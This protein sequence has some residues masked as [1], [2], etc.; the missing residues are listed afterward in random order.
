VAFVPLYINKKL[1]LIFYPFF[2]R[3]YVYR[4]AVDKT[5]SRNACQ[6]PSAV[7]HN[8][9]LRFRILERIKS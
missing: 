5:A 4:R 7:H 6:I 9:T 8:Y 2:S 1:E 3:R